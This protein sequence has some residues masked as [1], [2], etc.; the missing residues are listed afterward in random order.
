MAFGS[1]YSVQYTDTVPHE[2]LS[3]V[4]FTT[5]SVPDLL[6][7]LDCVTK[8]AVLIPTVNGGALHASHIYPQI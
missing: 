1:W 3:L 2:Q 6:F 5:L 7:L 4:G 8:T